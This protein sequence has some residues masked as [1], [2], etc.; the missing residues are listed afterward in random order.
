MFYQF[1]IKRP[2]FASVCS[3]L[4][5][6]VG[7]VGYGSLPVQELP[8]IDPPVVSVTTTYPG[9]N[10][11][12]VETE[13]T[14]ILEAELNGVEGVRTLT[15]ESREGVSSITVQFQLD[16]DIDIGAQ[17][18]QRSISQ[19]L[20]QLPD[21]VDSPVIRRESGDAAPI[22]WFSIYGDNN[23]VSTL[24]LSD[25]ADRVLVDALESVNGV[26]SIFVGGERR[27]AMRLWID[28]QRL[29][30]RNLTILDV[31][32]VLRQENIELPSGRLEG[33]RSEFSVRTLGRLQE[34]EEYEALVLRTTSDGTQIRFSDV[35]YAEIGAEDE[36]SFVRFNGRPA[37]GLG[38]VKLATANTL[39]VAADARAEMERLR[40]DF[41]PGMDYEVAVDNSEFVQLAIDE[42]WSALYLASFLVVLVIF[43][44]LRDWRATIIPAVTIPVSLISAFGVMFI[45]DFSI[46]TLTLFA[47]TLA[48]GLV[49]DDTIV[50]LENIVRY[51]EQEEMKPY[52]AA[53]KGLEEVV[54][55]VI[56][57]TVVLVAVFLPVGFATGV[58]GQLFAEFALT[59]A[60]SVI[61]S[62]FVALTLAPT[63]A[64]RVLKSH[65]MLHG[66]IFD[67]VEDLL[68]ATANFY[69]SSL[70]LAL[71][72]K[73]VVVVAFV[74]SL[75]L[76]W[77]LFTQIPQGFLPAEDRGQ[78]L[79]IVNAPQGVTI[80][81]TDD[82]MQ[83]VEAIYEEIPEV[84][85]YF[86][87]GA[88][89]GGGP[90]QVNQGI[91]FV[92]L[93]PW[94]ERTQPQQSQQAIV[95]QLF[96]RFS[97]I[98]DAL[99]FPVNPPALPGAGF[100]QP[101]QLV[102]QGASL[103]QL[104]EISG[105]LAQRANAL[106]ELMNVDT[107]LKITQPEVTVAID[108]QKAAALG[109]NARDIANTLQI[110]LGGQQITSF[111]RENRRYE[112]VVQA[113]ERFRLSPQRLQELSLRTSEGE[114]VPLG[115]LVR[116]ETSTTPPQ[117]E[118]YQRFRSATIEGSPAAGY[119]LG[120]AIAALQTLA[121][122]MV[123]ADINTELAGESLEFQEAGDATAFIFGL[124]MAFIFLVLSAQF[125]SYLDPIVVL[126]A[127]PLSL[128]GALGALLLAGLELN[129]YSQI[130]LIMLI[131]L[132][133]K[134]SIL[135]V[136]FANQ[137]RDEGLS[138]YRAVVEAG[139]I[140]FRPILMTAFS[141]I[142]GLMPLAFASG[143]GAASR[144][145]IG[146]SVVG[147]MFVA[148]ILSL[149]VVPVFYLIINGVQ[150]RLVRT[151]HLEPEH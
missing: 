94:E 72:F 79:T 136:E 25:Y 12:V 151:L 109:I 68:N 49:V 16:Q 56:A 106:P 48:T 73:T 113:E 117:I 45:L 66:W 38:V 124:A 87:I 29:S 133:T 86:T 59:L 22:I 123:P 91:A 105:D 23:S 122:E 142:F 82:V 47:L 102:L 51:I 99:I 132:A 69:A 95:G 148:T 149:Y 24:E 58:T 147:G 65:S 9:A 33:E 138:I 103:E 18:V 30:A 84:R 2:V 64:A 81:Y 52:H 17:E 85:Y 3:L 80:N 7:L 76:L 4:L 71:S 120:E 110:L 78:V 108:R 77:I 97:Q 98:S 40:A 46:N 6:L 115:N 5:M 44:F 60:G 96:G 104:A 139:R 28:P 140:R 90:G 36:R 100:G 134:N 129:V 127:V 93:Q 20:G 128:I 144:V 121:D 89:G 15:S 125:E 116:L 67:K 145:S 57:T 130:G 43:F 114:L 101:V 35:G 150:T 54:F 111:N 34:P 53:I 11:S 32:N 63:L 31:E 61:V 14:E 19:V 143:A 10:P 88:F 1:F 13:V 141:T 146:M 126:L 55:A 107:T 39:E 74:F 83:Q 137:K 26:S 42:V 8:S 41:P 131:G 50:V 21:D 62:S 70:R 75:G 92:R 112:V 118:H 119:S 135:I 27:Y 37:V